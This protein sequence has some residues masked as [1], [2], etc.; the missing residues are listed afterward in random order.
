MTIL[1]QWFGGP[2]DGKV[3]VFPEGTHEVNVPLFNVRDIMQLDL[4]EA[5]SR[6]R[7]TTCVL[8]RTEHGFIIVWKEPK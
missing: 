1:A 5:A 4:D 6:I 3:Y 7:Y 8:R 2:F